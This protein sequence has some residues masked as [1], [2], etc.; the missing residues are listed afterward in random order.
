MRNASDWSR[1]VRR[2]TAG[3]AV[4]LTATGTLAACGGSSGSNGAS[5]AKNCTVRSLLVSNLT[6]PGA[7]NGTQ[8]KAAAEVAKKQINDAGG[9]NGCTLSVDYADDTSDYTTNLPLT[10]KALA[11]KKYAMVQGADFGA[12]SIAPYL[13][14]QK[15]L[16]MFSN[17]TKGLPDPAVNPYLFDTTTTGADVVTAVAKY[18]VSQGDK[19][20]AVVADNT[21]VGKSVIGAV[22]GVLE[23]SGGK[24]VSSEQVDL[25]NVN[26]TPAVQR[27]KGSG[28]KTILV[29]LFGAAG[30]HFFSAL[31]ASGWK[32]T[33]Y[34]SQSVFATNLAALIP[35]KDFAGIVAGGGTYATS[36]SSD[37][38]KAFFEQLKASGYDTTKGIYSTAP[39][40][41]DLILFAAAANAT[42]STDAA[43]MTKWLE[44]N[45][46]TTI[47]GLVL[48]S[49]TGYSS[50]NHEWH[51]PGSL[52]TAKMGALDEFGLLPR[53][54]TIN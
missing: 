47:D 50:T 9:I 40:H 49:T 14:R 22:K 19:E 2:L 17:G 21:G 12:G 44:D 24:L 27:L 35:V 31:S 7:S 30:G 51:A 26:M 37:R 11:Q 48:A 39:A 3:V 34:G 41:D 25:S 6:G 8:N 10:Q 1:R 16:G 53:I 20:I 33:V 42:K 32:P 36:P 23:S 54:A 45:G 4:V 46:T 38:A 28:A 5:G 43:K 15:I 29:S 52:S 18:A 13:T